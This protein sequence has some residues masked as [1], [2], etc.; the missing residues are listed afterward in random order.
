MFFIKKLV[1]FFIWSLKLFIRYLF[2]WARLRFFSASL[3]FYNLT[4]VTFYKPLRYWFITLNPW[5]TLKKTWWLTAFMEELWDELW[6]RVDFWMDILDTI[7]WEVLGL[8]IDFA[9]SLFIELQPTVVDL[10][11]YLEDSSIEFLQK[12]E[13]VLSEIADSNLEFFLR[14]H[15]PTFYL[16]SRATVIIPLSRVLDHRN[17]IENSADLLFF[18]AEA[19]QLELEEELLWY[20]T[21]VRN[22]PNIFKNLILYKIASL[23]Y[24]GHV[25]NGLRG[26][27]SFLSKTVDYFHIFLFESYKLKHPAFNFLIKFHYSSVL[28][29]YYI[30]FNSTVIFKKKVRLWSRCAERLAPSLEVDIRRCFR[31]FLF[32]SK[33]ASTLFFTSFLRNQFVIFVFFKT[34]LLN[35][36]SARAALKKIT[37]QGGRVLQ[38]SHFSTRVYKLKK[39]TFVIRK[40]L[41]SLSKRVSTALWYPLKAAKSDKIGLLCTQ[42]GYNSI[43]QY[44]TYKNRS[45]LHEKK[46]SNL[47]VPHLAFN[48]FLYNPTGVVTLDNIAQAVLWKKPKGCFRLLG[49]VKQNSSIINGLKNL[50][51]LPGVVLKLK[52]IK[53]REPKQLVYLIVLLPPVLIIFYTGVFIFYLKFFNYFKHEPALFICRYINLN[54]A[55]SGELPNQNLWI[56]LTGIYFLI[57]FDL[58]SLFYDHA[59][60]G[61][62]HF[63]QTALFIN[64]NPTPSNSFSHLFY[65]FLDFV[66]PDAVTN[67]FWPIDPERIS[68]S[69][70]S[71][72]S[73]VNNKLKDK[74]VIQLPPRGV[75][76]AQIKNNSH[77]SGCAWPFK[78]QKLSS[79]GPRLG[80]SKPVK[81]SCS[82]RVLKDLRLK[83]FVDLLVVIRLSVFKFTKSGI[84]SWI[85]INP[86]QSGFFFASATIGSIFILCGLLIPEIFYTSWASFT[87]WQVA[88][89]VGL[90]ILDFDCKNPEHFNRLTDEVSNQKPLFLDN[91]PI[92]KLDCKNSEYFTSALDPKKDLTYYFI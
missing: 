35:S 65:R 59:I 16:A 64:R 53:V 4:I 26:L 24:G 61:L 72:S 89:C 37:K 36:Y 32:L 28:A 86:A 92:W 5:N 14:K 6:F 21:A 84:T 52:K 30:F 70:F 7:I 87:D 67:F 10:L 90:E 22:S 71:I 41:L 91:H 85:F 81:I 11:K 15:G 78:P 2:R 73:K 8:L 18:H 27:D 55:P 12:A 29:R 60:R 46:I 76:A 80:P 39:G 42:S 75:V 45:D 74:P 82:S 13:V 79:K 63:S 77:R 20:Y 33:R 34:K 50:V 23:I 66:E 83:S 48:T 38:N 57:E 62:L 31:V 54:E 40:Q 56:T 17:K 3:S 69:L 47:I 43:I 51:N 88:S 44:H 58:H 1:R 49:F 25:V 19:F 68:D 9:Y